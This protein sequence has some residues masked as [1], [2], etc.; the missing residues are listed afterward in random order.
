MNWFSNVFSY[1]G[2]F[3][4]RTRDYL[5]SGFLPF[6]IFGTSPQFNDYTRD[7]QKLAVI[8][9]NPALLKVFCLQCDLF[10]LGKVYVYDENDKEIE[11]DPAVNRIANPNFMQNQSQWLW[12]YMFWKMVGNAYLY[13]ES[14]LVERDNAPM[15]W[16][17]THK[18][19]WPT[20]LDKVKDKFIFSQAKLNELMGT[21]ITYRYEDG[22][23]FKFPLSKIATVSDL[24]NGVGNWF[25]GHSRID[26]LYKVISN[27]ETS[28]DSKNINVRFT[29]KF[30][31]AGQQ[32]P[33]D[34]TKLPMPEDEKQDIEKKINGEKQ[35]HAVKSLVD[36]K[37]F[38]DD[39]RVL[40]LDKSYLADYYL[41]G[42]M[43]NIPR[44]VLEA[45]AS[46]TFENQEKAR[47]GHV[48]YTL[49]PAGEILGATL[50]KKW[51][52]DLQGKKICL[53]WDH[54]PFVQVFEKDRMAMKSQQINTFNAMRKAG[55][56][57]EEINEFLDLNFTIDETELERQQQAAG[58]TANGAARKHGR[59]G[60]TEAANAGA[61]ESN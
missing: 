43:Y 45:Y 59:N 56:P 7:A 57:I 51:G 33:N 29:A 31:V 8:F 46:S 18:I 61:V 38:V 30:L 32:D 49:E 14:K 55:I 44:D 34:V 16:L 39:L 1:F 41:I 19:E 2:S 23:V 50:G 53:S 10:S 15:Y 3:F 13:M 60:K 20:E 5:K 4:N 58:A 22:T 6:H 37:R 40:E 54:L 25:K 48:S 12:D 35:V 27:S 9:S 52:Y 17:E 21:V 42:S 11:G 24:T 26:A 28:L 36:I 47:A